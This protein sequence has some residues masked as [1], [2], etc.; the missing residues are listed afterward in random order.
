MNRSYIF[1]LIMCLTELSEYFID[2]ERCK[3][4]DFRPTFRRFELFNERRV[5]GVFPLVFN[6]GKIIEKYSSF[7]PYL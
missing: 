6:K 5:G 1:K 3:T 2:V 4:F 7:Y